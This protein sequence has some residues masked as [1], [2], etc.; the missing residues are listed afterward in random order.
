MPSISH[1]LRIVP[2]RVLPQPLADSVVAAAPT[3]NLTYRGGPLLTAVEVVTVFWGTQWETK[4]G[5]VA[6]AFFDFILITCNA[7]LG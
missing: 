7:V 2:L 6:N 5:G 4:Q 3:P 1:P